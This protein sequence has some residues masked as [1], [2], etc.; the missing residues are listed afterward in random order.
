MQ[1]ENHWTGKSKKYKAKVL[2][3]LKALYGDG[4]VSASVQKKPKAKASPKKTIPSEAQ[5]QRALVAWIRNNPKIAPYLIKLNNEGKRTSIQGFHLKAMGMQPG[6]SDLF[7]AYPVGALHGLWIEMKRNRT[8]TPYETR[9]SS[10]EA[11]IAFLERMRSVGFRAEVCYGAN[12][13]KSIVE[14]YLSSVV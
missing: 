1:Y 12:H 3:S 8:Y 4:E 10:W 2:D 5:E 13:G 7:L 14:S 9:S 6:A 11:Q